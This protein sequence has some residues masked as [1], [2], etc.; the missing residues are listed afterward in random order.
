M[1]PEYGWALLCGVIGYLLKE[2]IGSFRKSDKSHDGAIK[3]NTDAIW[4]L[5]IELGKFNAQIAPLL[6]MRSEL[7]EVE[8][9]VE[10]ISTVLHLS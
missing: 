4:N 7:T 9:Q 2:F 8:K 1:T 5:K 10:R 6:E 3:E